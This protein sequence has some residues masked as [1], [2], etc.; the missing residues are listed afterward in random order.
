[1]N[2][3]MAGLCVHHQLADFIQTHVHRVRDDMQPSHPLLSP[4]PPAPF[5]E[6]RRASWG[7]GKAVFEHWIRWVPVPCLGKYE[8]II[9][10]QMEAAICKDAEAETPVLW[11]PEAK[12]WLIEKDP[13]AGKDRRWDEKGTKEDEVVEWHHWLDGHEF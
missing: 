11:P 13:D 8:V 10:N 2:C 9:A 6:M 4:S 5:E 7:K 12:G 1:M 3:S